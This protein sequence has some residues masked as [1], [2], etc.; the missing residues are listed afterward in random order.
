MGLEAAGRGAEEQA[1][2]RA[3][4]MAQL[5][6]DAER[7][8]AVDEAA[9]ER[10]RRNQQAWSAGAEGE[11]RVA[12]SL[13][14]LERFGW[15]MLHDVRWPGR[16][17][18]NVDHIAIGPGGVF[19]VDAKNWSG[20]VRVTSQAVRQNGYGRASSLEGVKQV[21]AAVTAILAPQHRSAVRGVMCLAGQQDQPVRTV[22][23]VVVCG[24]W[25]LPEHLLAAPQRL[26]VL[27]VADIARYLTRELDQ[28]ESATRV[29]GTRAPSIQ[30]AAGPARARRPAGLAGYVLLAV[31]AAL[32]LPAGAAGVV[33]VAAVMLFLGALWT[34]LSGRRFAFLS[35][36]L[37]GLGG[38]FLAFV[39]MVASGVMVGTGSSMDDAPRSPPAQSTPVP[40]GAATS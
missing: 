30:P 39:L 15:T 17:V 11:R 12:E 31:A 26:T 2:R 37:R 18:A 21:T 9:F 19:V 10:L 25:Q 23:G 34:V 35:S 20:D 14:S 8:A 36:R 16:R 1:T 29:R 7:G 3:R 28:G 5:R 24:R 4:R 33:A 22:D 40:P 13:A 27:D 38:L 32:G 6:A